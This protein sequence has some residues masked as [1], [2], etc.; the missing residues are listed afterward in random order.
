MRRVLGSL[1]VIL[2]L[3]LAVGCKPKSEGDV[4]EKSKSAPS[5]SKVTLDFHIMSKCPFGVKVI[6]AITPVIEKMGDAVQF[7]VHYIG[8]EKDGELTS[9]H[10]E[11][12]VKGNITQLCAN[13]IGDRAAWLEFLKCQNENWRKIPEGWED[14]A[15]TAKLDMTKMKSCVDGDQGK[16][17]FKASIKASSDKKATGSPTIFLDG[18]PYRSGRSETSFGRAI[19]A[20]MSEPKVA[21][22]K[23][24]PAPTKVP[25]TI[26]ADKRC[27]GRGCNPKRF[28]SFISHTFEGA[29]IKELDYSD[30]EGAALFEKS[31]QQFL[32]IAVFGPE[33]K[34]EEAGYKRLKRRLAEIEGTEELVYPLGRN[35][36]PKAEIC[37]DG[38]DN[39]DNGKVDCDDESCQGK[40]ICREEIKNKLDLFVMSQCPY[41]VRT[42]DAMKDVIE[43]FGKNS[44]LMDFELN[45]IGQERDGKLTSMHGQGEVDENLR[46]I[47]AQKIYKKNYKFMDYVLCRNKDYRST[48][49]ESCAKD[50]IKAD[51]IK[52]CA[53]GEEGKALLAASFKMA[54]D[55][56]ISG[57][58]SWLLNNKYDMNA[59]N[60][61]AI[62]KAFCGKNEGVKGCDKKLSTSSNAPPAGSCGGGPAPR[63][64]AKKPD[65]KGKPVAP[66]PAGGAKKPAPP[67]KPAEKAEK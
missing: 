16:N 51:A 41:G 12:E 64:G 21:Y 55:L 37:D 33:V 35:W 20:K 52:K 36:D 49:W 62:K 19:C 46:Q 17:L 61:E 60:P 47:C 4:E 6:Q 54:K 24:I 63:A 42:V 27:T 50:G 28:M 2:S 53:E 44:K 11:Q 15:K 30:S 48:D 9:M 58:P 32:P 18:E 67:K 5:T 39:T 40:K 14:C 10:G 31:G 56:G 59:R 29:E 65:P 13:E 45:F 7:N 66:P 38:K 22:C 26:V 43:N 25:V 8:K 1:F 34:K 23:D 57:S 3:T